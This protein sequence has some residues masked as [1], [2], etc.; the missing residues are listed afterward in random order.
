MYLC[1][2]NESL[3]DCTIMCE[4]SAVR[5]HK[6]VLSACSPYFQKI[7]VD[8][9]GKH[10]IIVLKDVRCWEMQCILDFMYKGETSVPEPQLTSLIK[11]AESLKVRGLTSSDQL[12]PGVSISASPTNLSSSYRSRAGYSPS[13]SPQDRSAGYDRESSHKLSHLSGPHSNESSPMSLTATD[14]RASPVPGSNCPRRKQARPRRRSG[15]SVNSSL[16]LSKAGSPPLAYSKR[17]SPGSVAGSEEHGGPADLSLRRSHSPSHGHTPAIN[18]VKMEQLVEDR[19]RRMEENISDESLDRERD[20]DR[21]PPGLTNGLHNMH[22][23][24]SST[25]NQ[26]TEQPS[27]P[28]MTCFAQEAL[29]ALNFMASGGG[30]PH[31]PLLPPPGQLHSP[32]HPLHSPNHFQN[33]TALHKPSPP[34][35]SASNY[36]GE[37]SHHSYTERRADNSIPSSA[38]PL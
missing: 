28:A 9:P 11:A 35:S 3:V 6:V 17:E 26:P 10:P 13:P 7:F 23:Q 33:L 25:T 4:D 30:L 32:L 1:R 31:H 27:R 34:T 36:T 21:K 12:P 15:D 5:A 24:V 16:D 22:E 20:C 8:N 29:Q 14:G 19:E 2:Q 38:G 18:L 37:Y